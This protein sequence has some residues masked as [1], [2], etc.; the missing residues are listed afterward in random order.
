ML[1]RRLPA[2]LRL[3]RASDAHEAWRIVEERPELIPAAMNAMLIGFTSFCRDPKVFR[4]L[5]AVVLPELTRRFG[6]LRAWSA[7]CSDGPELYSLAVL[8]AEAG[9]LRSCDLLGTDCRPEAI[10]RARTGS[11]PEAMLAALAPM[12]RIAYFDPDEGRLQASAILKAPISWKRASLFSGP[13]PGPW[14]LIMWR[15]MAIYLDSAAADDIWG[16]L[17]AELAPG[18]ILVTGKA[19]LP[20]R[21]LRLARVGSCIY[22]KAEA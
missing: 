14:H 22:R 16:R 3:L 15:N 13:E 17:V 2:C 8:L 5:G 18:G 4:E 1:A 20:P 21:S 7:A 12:S 10:R 11:Y 9:R 19:E 6:L